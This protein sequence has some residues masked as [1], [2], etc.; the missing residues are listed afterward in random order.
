M[1]TALFYGKTGS[2]TLAV[3]DSFLRW[4]CPRA[5]VLPQRTGGVNPGGTSGQ[6]VPKQRR[7]A[8]GVVNGTWN[9]GR[10]GMSQ[11]TVL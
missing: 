5:P 9:S 11:V 7:R 8:K 2:A 4:L 6:N 10:N 1:P 3:I